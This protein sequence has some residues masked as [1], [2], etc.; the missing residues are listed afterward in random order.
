M[1]NES[2]NKKKNILLIALK[3]HKYSLAFVLFFVFA[4]T[5]FAWFIYNK[6]VDMGLNAHVK[7]WDIHLAAGDGETYTFNLSDLY[8]GMPEA[9]DSVVVVNDGEMDADLSFTVKELVLFGETK[10]LNTDYT[11]TVNNGVYTINGFPF[12]LSFS[13]TSDSVSAGAQT[14]LS[15]VLNWDY[16]NNEPEC[17]GTDAGGEPYNICD[18]EDTELGE[19]SYEYSQTNPDDPSLAIV[20][21][22]QFQEAR[23]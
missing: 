9:T 11:V 6:T 20:L 18:A 13:L 10:T 23:P 21:R 17:Q 2:D 15:F 22:L 5:A 14:T 12:E 1:K 4:S 3:R 16:D 8:P 19:K 7:A